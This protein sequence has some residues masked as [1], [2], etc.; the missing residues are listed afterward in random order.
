M[1]MVI[2]LRLENIQL[3]YLGDLKSNNDRSPNNTR[4]RIK[5]LSSI[6]GNPKPAKHSNKAKI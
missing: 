2:I 3:Q 6:T 1:G 4:T 5:A